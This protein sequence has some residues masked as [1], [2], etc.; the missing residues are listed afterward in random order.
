[1]ASSPDSNFPPPN[2]DLCFASL[3]QYAYSSR[4]EGSIGISST[5]ASLQNPAGSAGP[6]KAGTA[7]NLLESEGASNP[8]ARY[9]EHEEGVASRFPPTKGL[10]NRPRRAQS[11][12]VRSSFASEPPPSNRATEPLLSVVRRGLPNGAFIFTLAAATPVRV[13][14]IQ[15]SLVI[16]LSAIH[17]ASDLAANH[18][19]DQF[20]VCV[21]VT[22]GSPE[23]FAC[24]RRAGC[25]G[26][27]GRALI[28]DHRK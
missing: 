23:A 5:R 18:G 12:A 24:A 14:E 15:S 21:L 13:F 20:H 22:C 26:I 8:D 27:R 19:T 2:V 11:R 1:M 7:W 17:G 10:N 3:A 9:D 16:N 4:I 28:S 6:V 25:A